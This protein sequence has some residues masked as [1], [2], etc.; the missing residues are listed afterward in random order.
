VKG[1]RD[2][3]DF[4]EVVQNVLVQQVGEQ[5]RQR[6]QQTGGGVEG[7]SGAPGGRCG[8]ECGEKQQ[9]E[10]KALWLDGDGKADGDAES[11]GE[12]KPAAA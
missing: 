10:E 8:P 4:E 2:R 3:H 5:D 7:D 9:S 6:E 12:V 1:N 11:R